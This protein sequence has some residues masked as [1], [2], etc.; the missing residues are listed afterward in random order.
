MNRAHGR[1]GGT[2]LHSSRAHHRHFPPICCAGCPRGSP[3]A[4]WCPHAPSEAHQTGPGKGSLTQ[5]DVLT[6]RW[7]AVSLQLP[8]GHQLVRP[9]FPNVDAFSHLENLLHD[10]HPVSVWVQ[11]QNTSEPAPRGSTHAHTSFYYVKQEL[12]LPETQQQVQGRCSS[13]PSGAE[14]STDHC[15]PATAGLARAHS[16][17][18]AHL[19]LQE[20]TS[21]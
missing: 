19:A 13:D 16:H 7:R 21:D 2:A 17:T 9:R 10:L 6:V 20:P 18:L 15:P 11:Q 1:G 12:K 3:T 4:P 14:H 5:A 8:V